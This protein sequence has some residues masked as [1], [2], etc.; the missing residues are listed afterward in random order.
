MKQLFTIILLLSTTLVISQ[1]SFQE[2]PVAQNI[3]GV[4][5]VAT[6]DIDNDGDLDV[7]SA[8]FF[9]NTIAW[10]ENTDG[11]GNFG[12]IQIIS[13][14]ISQT[15]SIFAADID[16]DGDMD[17]I[18]GA[19][20]GSNTVS[21]HE[22]TDGQG[23][24]AMN[25]LS[26]SG[27]TD[28]VFAVDLDNDNDLDILTASFS[29]DRVL[30]YENLDGEG[31][32]GPQQIIASNVDGAISV[33]AAD[34]DNDND[35]DVVFAAL[36][37]DF[38]GWSEN[39]DGQ[40]SFDPFE[41][42]LDNIDAPV[43]V[44]AADM[45]GDNTIDIVTSIR[46]EDTVAWFQ[47]NNGQG[48]FGSRQDIA[49]NLDFVV[50]VVVDDID[51][52]NDMDVIAGVSDGNAT[53]WMENIDGQG[54]FSS[55]QIIIEGPSSADVLGIVTADIDADN[56]IDVVVSSFSGNTINWYEN[57]GVLGINDTEITN[58]TVFPNPAKDF[59]QIESELQIHQVKVYDALGRMVL[60][61]SDGNRV[62]I[63]LLSAG[64]YNVEM[65][66]LNGLKEI[67][68]IVKKD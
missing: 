33:F 28:D 31:N 16:N 60:S 56:D 25:I 29:T 48:D 24:F 27:S 23:N 39:T 6:A 61:E 58:A 49:G 18:S 50:P 9:D 1:I 35:N 2:N 59:I 54:N 22:N 38:I 8:A 67:R 42:I 55:P 17:I 15:A 4:A 63:S 44:Y 19:G 7:V 66:F 52:D 30:W 20:S 57:S 65:E 64:Y 41:I 36:S 11:Q 51:G 45:D 3:N 21:W 53:V 32:F 37:G 10:Y 5:D 46:N 14:I 40:G 26:S 43:S 62:N 47:N 34:L 13:S 12:Q 68:K